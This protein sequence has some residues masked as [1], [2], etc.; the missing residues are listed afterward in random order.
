MTTDPAS[1]RAGV[2]VRTRI[3]IAVALLTGLALAGAGLVVYA[4]SSARIDRAVQDQV[5]QELAEFAELQSRGIDPGSRP[6]RAFDDVRRLIE[7]FLQRNVPDENELLVGWW[8]GGPK[9]FQGDVHEDLL[10]DPAFRRAV[11]ER[12]ATG[13]S[14]SLDTRWGEVSVTVQPARDRQTRGAFV[15]ASFLEDE[16]RALREV[17]RTY[18]I[19]SV[20]SLGLVA[21]LAAWQ[22]DR[23]LRPLRSLRETAQAISESDLSRR[24]PETGHDDITALTRTIN[25]MLERLET[26][27]TGQRQFLDDAGHEL[28]TPLTVIRGHMELLDSGDPAEVEATR[29]LLLDEVD[30]MSRLVGD[31]IMLAKTARPDF[32]RPDTVDLAPYTRTVLDKC[33]A[34][35][36]R[37]WVL[38]DRADVLAWLDEQ[39]L[40]QA[41]LQLAENAVKHT[42][43]GDEIGVGS[44]VDGGHRVRLWVRDTGSGV[45]DDDKALVFDRFA[46]SAVPHGDDGFGLG[47]SIVRGIA[48]A[49][50]GDAVVEDAEPH[51]ARFVLT[52][53]VRRKDD[54][55]PAS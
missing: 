45:P 9:R 3:A 18:A 39:R 35:G 49:H 54:P 7:V 53:P 30:R 36:D 19:V 11:A 16:H 23:L 40:T 31:L 15:V 14:T 42:R 17:M 52:L 6:P 34:L 10:Y 50:G 26:A 32:L 4:L 2:P 41:M 21:A 29:E 38:D 22:A 12:V 20:L 13:G 8:N 33:R 51:G 46:R 24:I 44:R 47:L 5:E 27:F 28:R 43:P 48:S 1:R 55:W 37:R 25:E